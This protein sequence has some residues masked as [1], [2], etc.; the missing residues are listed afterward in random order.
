[1]GRVPIMN[2]SFQKKYIFVTVFKSFGFQAPTANG[3]GMTMTHKMERKYETKSGKEDQSRHDNLTVLSWTW[4]S[5]VGTIVCIF[6]ALTDSP[7]ALMIILSEEGQECWQK[8]QWSQQRLFDNM[9]S[10]RAENFWH[11]KKT[12]TYRGKKSSVCRRNN[13]CSIT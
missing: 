12:T 9:S 6:G 7:I 4:Q 3:S 13:V 11:Y 10:G 5:H 2:S 1:M 8:P